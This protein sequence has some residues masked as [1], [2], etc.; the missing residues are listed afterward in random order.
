MDAV[1][2]EAGVS[3]A[4]VHYYFST[5]DALL[6]AAFSHSEDRANAR[7]EAEVLLADSPADKLERF[8]L[9]DLGEEAVFDENRTLWSEVWAGMRI[10]E[11][12]RPYVEQHY[13]AWFERLTALVEEAAEERALPGGSYD[14]VAHRLAALVDGVDSLLLVGLLTHERACALIRES[15][16]NE[17]G[18]AAP[19]AGNRGG[20]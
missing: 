16:A 15:V 7:V 18:I 3:K 5:R 8:L 10:D 13:R 20:N 6:R 1:A 14:D 12:L 17:L 9:L 19:T 4:L 2:R 11:K